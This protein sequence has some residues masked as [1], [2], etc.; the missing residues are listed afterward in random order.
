MKRIVREDFSK[1]YR[2]GFDYLGPFLYGFT[3]WLKKSIDNNSYKK[4]FF[5]SRD[6]YLME[7]AF[8]LM[9]N[10]KTNTEYVYVSRKSLRQ[11]LLWK[12]DTLA[13]S[14]QYLGWERFISVGKILEYFGFD[15]EERTHIID[16]MGFDENRDIAFSAICKDKE[17]QD[18]F[19]TYHDQIVV[20][21]KQ[22]ADL[23][24]KYINQIGMVGKCAIVDIGWHGSMQ[25]YLEL[26]CRDNLVG[27]E[28]DGYYVGILP[29]VPLESKAYGYAYS[30]KNP[31]NR[32]KILCFFGGYE[33]LFQG[34]D[35]STLGYTTNTEGT[36]IPQ[37]GEYEYC[38]KEDREL[39]KRIKEWQQGA[40]SYVERDLGR[41]T[42]DEKLMRSL[43]VFGSKPSLEETKIFEGFYTYD[44]A[45]RYFTCRKCLLSYK[46]KEFIHDLSNSQWKTGFL[47]SA[48]K[49]PF[50]YFLIYEVL[51]K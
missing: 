6:G 37:L 8:R 9:D 25:Y 21:S 1:Y 34:F 33:R 12:Y 32:K 44:G 15:Y 13:E 35:G 17:I 19:N 40:L 45:K 11:A 3:R 39:V 24:L 41:N 2:F 42:K 51:R 43:I 14:L 28:V 18:F 16:N 29:N 36:I 47:K 5:F 38:R 31:G 50:P 49:I 22:Q 4:V 26:F 10:D 30:E 46:L 20:K 48:F 23:L 7:K 27:C